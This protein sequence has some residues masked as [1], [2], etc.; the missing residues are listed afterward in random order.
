RLV[1]GQGK[2]AIYGWHRPSGIPIQP[3]STVHGASYADYSHGIRLISNRLL[4]N[5][6]PRLYYEVLED[7][8]RAELLSDEGVIP[9]IRSLLTAFLRLPEKGR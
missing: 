6:K 5:G 9:Q 8:A 3:L 1:P 2:I 4:L 7:P